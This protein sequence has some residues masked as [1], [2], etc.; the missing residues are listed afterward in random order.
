MPN[1]SAFFRL[2]ALIAVAGTTLSAAY[3]QN[4]DTVSVPANR[5]AVAVAAAAGQPLTKEEEKRLAD[6]LEDWMHYVRIHNF[7]LATAN[8][9]ALQESG[10]TDEQLTAL[11]DDRAAIAS[12]FIDTVVK[13][14]GVPGLEKPASELLAKYQRGRLAH[15]RNANEITRNIKLLSGNQSERLYATQRLKTAGEY[16]MP[17]LLAGLLDKSDVVR[18]AQVRRVVVEMGRHAIIPLCVALPDLDATNQEL[19]VGVLGDL[20]NPYTT[21]LPFLYEV[22]EAATSDRLRS[23]C[24]RAIQNIT[25][26]VSPGVPVSDRFQA[27]AVEYYAEPKSLTSFPGEDI[28]LLWAYDPGA[29][30]WATPIDTPVYHEAMAMRMAERALTHDAGNAESLSLWIA[31]NFSR[32]IDTPEG[33]SNPA[34]PPG[35][36]D[37]MYY[38]VAAGVQADERVLARALGEHD[39][40]LAR[41][42]IAAIE[43]TA[44]ANAMLNSNSGAVRSPLLDAI[45]YPNRRVQYDA[46]LAVGAAKP[47]REFVGADRIVPTLASAIRDASARY[48]VVLG[49]N[50]SDDNTIADALRAAGYT[51]LPTATSLA[52]IAQPIAE[53]PGIDL[54]VSQLPAA[55]TDQLIQEVR[56]RVGM[57]A[58]PVLAIVSMQGYLE[59]GKKYEDDLGTKVSREGLSP[60]QIV[61]AASQLITAYVGGMISP[62]EAKDYKLRALAV[63]R[64]LAVSGNDVLKVSYASAPLTTALADS[65]GDVRLRVG[66]VLSYIPEK[67][68]QVALMDAALNATGDEQIALLGL[69]ADSAKRSGNMLETR[70]VN[71]LM[72]LAMGDGTDEQ[73]TAA[74]ALMGALNL[75]NKDLI[76]LILGGK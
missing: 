16:A 43:K 29:G 3:A 26:A 48:A 58:T 31:A 75:P 12:R 59:L 36:R 65:T 37:A 15:A 32:E 44:G 72:K 57:A 11:V 53:A 35:R 68:V 23:A 61:A 25:G 18:Q 45:S 70:Q 67:S 8:A 38:A 34:Y 64:D 73:A 55:Q 17:Q 69:V 50:K 46:A 71:N 41:R 20:V 22:R 47:A 33:Y 19:V 1:R 49:M 13:A 5:A 9:R 10:L 6:L 76:P 66:E 62:D 52:D 54:V 39:T 14:Q 63:L 7:E 4:E 74:A 30:L 21:S 51:V 2:A 24:D 42:A 56:G 28:Q 60:D 27:L 40:P